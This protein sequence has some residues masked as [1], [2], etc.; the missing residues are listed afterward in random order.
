MDGIFNEILATIEYNI[1]GAINKVID[2]IFDGIFCKINRDELNVIT[3][4]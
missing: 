2:E 4:K 1:F 3:T